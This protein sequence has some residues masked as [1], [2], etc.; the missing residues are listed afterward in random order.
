MDTALVKAYA[1]VHCHL[2]T[3]QTE[4]L[5]LLTTRDSKRRTLDAIQQQLIGL[6]VSRFG[7]GFNRDPAP[8]TAVSSVVVLFLL[9]T[10]GLGLLYFGIC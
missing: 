7:P 8:R 9:V 4:V 3:T 5:L 1:A 10:V 2:E 6:L